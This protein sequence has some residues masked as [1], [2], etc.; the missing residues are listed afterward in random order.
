MIEG[1]MVRLTTLRKKHCKFLFK[2]WNDSEIMA[3]VGYPNYSISMPE[4][5]RSYINY[6]RKA[7]GWFLILTIDGVPIGDISYD[8]LLE[9]RTVEIHIKIGERQYWGQGYGADA[10]NVLV[11]YIFKHEKNIERVKAI[12]ALGNNRA[13]RLFEKCGFHKETNTKNTIIMTITRNE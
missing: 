11:S 8:V 12:P 1:K 9:E 3:P 4:V 10:V 6:I 2:W 13:T 5:R 7:G